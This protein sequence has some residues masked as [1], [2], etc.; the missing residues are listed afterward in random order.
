[1]WRGGR[2]VDP[3]SDLET[4]V[5]GHVVPTPRP[6]NL[7]SSLVPSAMLGWQDR[8]LYPGEIL[9]RRGGHDVGDILDAVILLESDAEVHPPSFLPLSLGE[10]LIY[11]LGG[12][13][14][15]ASFFS[16]ETS[17]CDGGRWSYYVCCLVCW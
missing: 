5:G 12:D 8:G 14:P 11:G 10:N 16:L 17:P 1:L 3:A 4:A 13:C 2:P 15:R 9:G 7:A 6:W